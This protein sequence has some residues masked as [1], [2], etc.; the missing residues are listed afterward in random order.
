MHPVLQA[1]IDIPRF[2]EPYDWTKVNIPRVSRMPARTN[3]LEPLLVIGEAK[4]RPANDNEQRTPWPL[5]DE[6]V[7]ERLGS[8]A[9]TNS[10]NWNTAI[11]IDR[12]YKIAML[13]EEALG[14]PHWISSG[15]SDDELDRYEPTEVVPKEAVS[16]LS[17]IAEVERIKRAERGYDLVGIHEASASADPTLPTGVEVRADANKILR[18]LM[19][20]MRGLWKPVKCAIVD[21]S[22]MW[23]LGITQGVSRQLAP[24][25][26]RQ[27]V[28]DGLGIAADI[29]RDVLRWEGIPH[30]LSGN[31]CSPLGSK[32]NDL[33]E[34]WRRAAN[35]DCRALTLAA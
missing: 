2:P 10:R 19:V 28:L 7:A 5:Y 12:I 29:R 25:A 23:K 17:M 22:E 35:D 13:P 4:A 34:H 30:R 24:T 20:G 11:W 3:Y 15:L 16:L 18:L 14:P 33:P 21:H 31:P 27:R 8:D 32:A 9:F 1:A 26:G 6:Y